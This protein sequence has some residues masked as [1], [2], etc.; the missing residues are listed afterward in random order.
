MIN[1]F[2]AYRNK[3]LKYFIISNILILIILNYGMD[4]ILAFGSNLNSSTIPI[5]KLI[6]ETTLTGTIL[7]LLTFVFDSVI[8][9]NIKNNMLLYLTLKRDIRFTQM[10]GEYIFSSLKVESKDLRIN[11][12]QVQLKYKNIY[13]KL[14]TDT[15]ERRRFENNHW[16]QLYNHYAK[17]DK[18]SVSLKEYLLCRDMTAS[19]C[20]FIMLYI[21]LYFLGIVSISFVILA[22]FILMYSVLL[23]CSRNKSKRYVLNVMVEDLYHESNH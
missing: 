8:P 5:I 19:F 9:V 23:T 18:I 13:D 3:E 14:P 6:V 2:K 16:Y 17:N 11:V 15:I 21:T 20:I 4:K 1:E 12:E 22:Y 7:Y 10:P